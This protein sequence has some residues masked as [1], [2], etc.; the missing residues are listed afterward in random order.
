MRNEKGIANQDMIQL[1]MDARVKDNGH[2]KLDMI[3]VT[4][5][6]FTLYFNAF[7]TTSNQICLIA[8][9]LALNPDI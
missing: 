3:G 5:Q 4:V 9:E 1:I 6:A 7:D 2:L 8:Y